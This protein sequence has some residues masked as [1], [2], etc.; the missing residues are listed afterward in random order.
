MPLPVLCFLLLLLPVSQAVRNRCRYLLDAFGIEVEL[1][2]DALEVGASSSL[3]K[4]TQQGKKEWTQ[5]APN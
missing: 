4:R 1:V 2:V 3:P 5:V